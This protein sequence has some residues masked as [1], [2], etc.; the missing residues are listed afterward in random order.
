M[1]PVRACRS[2]ISGEIF[3]KSAAAAK[4]NNRFGLAFS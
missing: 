4:V 1:T 2:N 3:N